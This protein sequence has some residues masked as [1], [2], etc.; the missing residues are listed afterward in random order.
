M[1]D[2]EIAVVPLLSVRNGT[3]A[4]EFYKTA[5]GEREVFRVDNE[6]GEVVARLSVGQA[7]F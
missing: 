4:I 7:E 1:A 5:F 6:K 3:R 2:Q